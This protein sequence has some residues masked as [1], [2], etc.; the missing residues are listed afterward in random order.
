M[1]AF[2]L[3]YLRYQKRRSPHTIQA[4]ADDLDQFA[5]FLRETGGPETD[6]VQKNHIRQWIVQLK[7]SGFA[8]T[9]INRKISTL[10]AYYHFLMREEKS[11]TNPASAV[12]SLKKP[13]KVPVF[14]RENN[15]LRLLENLENSSDFSALRD[16]VILELLYG[17]GMRLSELISLTWDSVNLHSKTVRVMGKRSKERIIPLHDTLIEILNQYRL[18]I[19][20]NLPNPTSSSLILTDKGKAAYPV[21]IERIVKKYLSLVMTEKK[22]S[23][24][25]LRHSFATHLLAAGAEINSIKELLGHSSLAATQVYTHNSVEQLR[26]AYSLAHPR[27]KKNDGGLFNK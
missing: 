18:S 5:T 1:I 3:Q 24:H 20:T 19:E 10:R 25:V 7:T 13:R 4:Y 12:S 11:E 6:A 17:T 26:K 9:S 21:L 16:R 27:A 22:R 8:E 23:P 14:V 2:F 15:L